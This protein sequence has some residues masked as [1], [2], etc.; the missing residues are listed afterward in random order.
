M[1]IKC[2]NIQSIQQAKMN[3]AYWVGWN[4]AWKKMR[5]QLALNKTI[6]PNPQTLTYQQL[7]QR[8]RTKINKTMLSAR[9]PPLSSVSHIKF[10]ISELKSKKYSI[11]TVNELGP[12]V[13]ESS[14][15]ISIFYA[16]TDSEH[17]F[18]K[19]EIE[20]WLPIGYNLGS[21]WL[22]TRSH[23]RYNAKPLMGRAFRFYIPI[24]KVLE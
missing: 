9:L 7:K 22:G 10:T 14:A 18:N 16:P 11:L 12:P 13:L 2:R 19:K 1:K 4:P 3:H 6:W 17:K 8:Q 23:N 15:R 20:N 5:F 24:H 21:S